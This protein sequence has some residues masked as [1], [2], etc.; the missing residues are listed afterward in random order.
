MNRENFFLKTS[1]L[2]L[3]FGY[4]TWTSI[5][6]I[7]SLG[8]LLSRGIHWTKFG[9][10]PAKGSRN[11]EWTIFFSKTSSLTLIFGHVTWKSIGLIY[12]LGS[13]TVP[14]WVLEIFKKKKIWEKDWILW[15]ILFKHNCTINTKFCDIYKLY[16]YIFSTIQSTNLT[17]N[18]PRTIINTPPSSVGWQSVLVITCCTCWKGKLCRKMK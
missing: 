15:C 11:I 6:V 18:C 14:S 7:Y 13:S 3:T 9:I 5:G 12:F 2:T 8:P 4:V 16:R 10:F 17:C 1:S